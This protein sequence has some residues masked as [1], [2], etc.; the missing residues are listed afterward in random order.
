VAA[1]QCG[2]HFA[3]ACSNLGRSVMLLPVFNHW[4]WPDK[5][6]STGRDRRLTELLVD[7]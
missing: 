2:I 7:D 1:A 3:L 4:D 5:H 6:S